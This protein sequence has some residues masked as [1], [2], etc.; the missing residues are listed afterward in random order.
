MVLYT[1][2]QGLNQSTTGSLDPH[3]PLL[4]LSV[5][6]LPIILI[7]ISFVFMKNDRNV[8]VVEE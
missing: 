4:P 5:Y 3:V 2:G 7:T 8:L 1:L 6:T